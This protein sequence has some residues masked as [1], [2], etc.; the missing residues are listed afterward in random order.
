[1]ATTTS[2][3]SVFPMDS[4]ATPT[5][6]DEGLPVY[7][8][9]Y[10]ASDFRRVMRTL[11]TD[12]VLTDYLDELTVD[13]DGATWSVAAGAA[14][15]NGLLINS[16]DAVDVIAQSEIAT[17]S[18][19][20]IIIAG[21]FDRADRNAQIYAVVQ[22]TADYTPTRTESKWELVLGRVDWRGIL[23]DYRLDDTY[24]GA[25]SP[26]E[27]VDTDS[28]VKSLKTAVSQFNLNVGTVTTLPPATTPTVTVRK[29]AA[30]GGDVYIDFGIPRGATGADGKDGEVKVPTT[31]V[32]PED[33][34]PQGVYETV[35][36][37]DD[38]D[39]HTITDIRV[40]QS[41]GVYP[42]DTTYPSESL[43]PGGEGDWV[44]HKIAAAL[45]A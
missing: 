34:P 11:Y 5:I 18:Y 45:V 4:S 14:I 26:F 31:Y 43:Y 1:M 42:S 27:P 9:A 17:D 22:S 30:A 35:W 6:N 8:R 33:N 41:A 19:A 39:T 15:A 29:P 16:E 40:Y 32:R 2:L 10:N 25:A 44:S 24:C 20:F 3:T 23:T 12:G 21:C 38:T 13:T 37:V 36:F 7:D 28:F